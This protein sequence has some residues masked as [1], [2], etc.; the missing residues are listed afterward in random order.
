M[1]EWR[2]RGENGVVWLGHGS[3]TMSLVLF[4]LFINGKT[5]SSGEVKCGEFKISLLLLWNDCDDCGLSGH[6][7]E[8]GERMRKHQSCGTL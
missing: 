6:I 2:V 3:E 1:R 5:D 7:T 8:G 4:S